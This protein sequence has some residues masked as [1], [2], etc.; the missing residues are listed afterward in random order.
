MSE[1]AL[2][3]IEVTEF[4]MAT[5]VSWLSEKDELPIEVTEFGMVTLVS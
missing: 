2:L 1:K 3:P 4:G 5:E